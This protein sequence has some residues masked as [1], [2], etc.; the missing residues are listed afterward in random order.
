MPAA[1][2]QEND[3]KKRTYLV[4]TDC[5]LFVEIQTGA[6]QIL[7]PCTNMLVIYEPRL[8]NPGLR[9]FRPG[10]TLTGLYSHRRC[11]PHVTHRHQ[12]DLDENKIK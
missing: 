2:G 1:R 9:G 8:E 12:V 10:P 4:E 6:P 3:R 5:R 7:V 11:N